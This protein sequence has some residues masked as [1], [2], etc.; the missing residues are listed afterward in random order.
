MLVKKK[1]K[2]YSTTKIATVNACVGTYICRFLVI[3]RKGVVVTLKISIITRR[4]EHVTSNRYVIRHVFSYPM[5]IFRMRRCDSVVESL[6][7]VS[8]W[9]SAVKRAIFG[10]FTR[11]SVDVFGMNSGKTRLKFGPY[12]KNDR[13]FRV[14]VATSSSP[15]PPD[16]PTDE[17]RESYALRNGGE[18]FS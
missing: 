1:K 18:G 11:I 9:K 6:G 3:R 10:A 14:D 13:K 2:M 12:R 7:M 5:E 8:D 16:R 17:G 15:P 4:R